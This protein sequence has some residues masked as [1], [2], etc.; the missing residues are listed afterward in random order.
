MRGRDYGEI[1]AIDADEEYGTGLVGDYQ[2]SNRGMI[3][4]F[5]PERG[6]FD[7]V[8]GYR[9]YVGGVKFLYRMSG[10]LLL[11]IV[12]NIVDEKVPEGDIDD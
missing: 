4:L 7:R 2:S 9:V 6:E 3:G 5:G 12:Q 8:D 1:F 10:S 11:N